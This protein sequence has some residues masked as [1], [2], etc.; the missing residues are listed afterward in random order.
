MLKQL[1]ETNF[2]PGQF[3]SAGNGYVLNNKTGKLA[4][5]Y[6]PDDRTPQSVL[7]YQFYLK[8]LKP[9]QQPM[10]YATF[11]TARARAAGATIRSSVDTPSGSTDDKQ[12]VEGP[13]NAQAAKAPAAPGAYTW[14]PEGGLSPK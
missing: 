12:R 2:G 6:A 10:D 14:S 5:G 13:G 1:I 4:R 7:E 11:S 8:S 3:S 9:G